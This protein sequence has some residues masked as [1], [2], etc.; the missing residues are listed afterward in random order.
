[1]RKRM[2]AVSLIATMLLLRF[3]QLTMP[4]IFVPAAL[5]LATYRLILPHLRSI[6]LTTTIIPIAAA[7]TMLTVLQLSPLLSV[8][9]MQRMLSSLSPILIM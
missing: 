2:I 1:M 8:T 3:P 7:T 6:S 5:P 4:V 9:S